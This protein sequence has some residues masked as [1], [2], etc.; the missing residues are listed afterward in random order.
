MESPALAACDKHRKNSMNLCASVGTTSA[1][2]VTKKTGVNS[3]LEDKEYFQKPAHFL[4]REASSLRTSK[5][6]TD[7]YNCVS[8]A[9]ICLLKSTGVEFNLPDAPA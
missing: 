2:K 1:T 6:A 7:S 4:T 3:L 8:S 9:L 5:E